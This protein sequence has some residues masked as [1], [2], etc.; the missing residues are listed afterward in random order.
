MILDRYLQDCHRN[1]WSGA[2]N[3]EHFS[4]FA[5]VLDFCSHWCPQPLP[6]KW[7]GLAVQ[8]RDIGISHP[9]QYG[10]RAS[11]SSIDRLIVLTFEQTS[12]RKSYSATCISLLID[13]HDPATQALNQYDIVAQRYFI[14]KYCVICDFLF[15]P[16]M[17][18]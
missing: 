8:I 15:N 7:I 11:E 9:S 12:H 10:S 3:V 6:L 5:S 1:Q 13:S 2:V 4:T 14:L 16:A 17:E 18:A